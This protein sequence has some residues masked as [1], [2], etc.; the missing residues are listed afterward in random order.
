MRNAV[1]LV[2][3]GVLVVCLCSCGRNQAAAKPNDPAVLAKGLVDSLSK[4]DF[5]SVVNG[6]DATMKAGLD[7]AKLKATWDGLVDQA[8]AFKKQTGVRVAKEQGL[9]VVYVT[10]VFER[11]ARL[12]A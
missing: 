7:E 6:F 10:C 12:L 4:Q 8:G 3:S 5:A 9:D 2:L 11:A 1:A